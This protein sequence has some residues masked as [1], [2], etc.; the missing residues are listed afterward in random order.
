MGNTP[1]DVTN[2]VK[3]QADA[4]DCDIYKLID[5]K[6]GGDLMKLMKDSV[7]K[8]TTDKLDEEIYK[9]V[10]GCL[11][12]KGRGEIVCLMKFYNINN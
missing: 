10:I 5:V 4:Q 2:N 1:S 6:G 7:L 3:A 11:Y 8:R 12:N 9:L